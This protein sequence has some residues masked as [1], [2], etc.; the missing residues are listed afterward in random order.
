MSKQTRKR[1]ATGKQHNGNLFRLLFAAVLL[2]MLMMPLTANRTGAEELRQ[3][4]PVILDVV[5]LDDVVIDDFQ[6]EPT[7]APTEDPLVIPD[8]DID[9][10]TIYDPSIYPNDIFVNPVLCPSD[11][12]LWS[13]DYYGLALNCQGG[14]ANGYEL[15]VT[16]SN[17]AWWIHNVI[18]DFG[19]GQSGLPS[20]TYRIDLYHPAGGGNNL[21]IICSADDM[22]G[23]DVVP[24]FD[25]AVDQFGGSLD[26]TG[27]LSYFC[28]VF[29]NLDGFGQ[30]DELI[31][32]YVNKHTCPEGVYSDN[33]Y[34]IAQVCQGTLEG[35]DFTLTDGLGAQTT[36]T[37]AGFP[38]MATFSQVANGTITLAEAIPAGYGNPIVFC[39]AEDLAGNELLGAYVVPTVDQGAF[40]LD[41]PAETY[42]VFCDVY[43]VPVDSDGGSIIIFKFECPA[44]YDFSAN[45]PLLDCGALL[46][47]VQFNTTGPDG[48]AAQ[49]NT[50]DSINGAVY[51]GGLEA[52]NYTITETLPPTMIQAYLGSCWSDTVDTSGYGN[53]YLGDP[54]AFQLD[55]AADED[56]VCYQYNAPAEDL[57]DNAE[58]FISKWECPDGYYSDT[59]QELLENCTTEQE[60]VV[61]NIEHE[62][63][64]T[65]S[66]DT[67]GQPARASFTPWFTGNSTITEEI[68]AGYGSPLV[69]C[70]AQDEFGAMIGGYDLAF[71][72]V[73][74]GAI[75]I[76]I[77]AIDGQIVTFS[78]DWFNFPDD[79][80][81]T[82]HKWECP[83]GIELGQ[84]LEYYLENCTVVMENVE[85]VQGQLDGLGELVYTDG[86]GNLSFSVDPNSDWVVQENVPTGYAD[87]V[88]FCGWGGYI[89]QDDDSVIA[90]DGFVNLDGTEGNTIEFQTYDEFG[91]DCNWFNIPTDDDQDI[92][93]YKYTCPEGYNLYGP[94]ADPKADCVDLTNGVNFHLLPEGGIELQSQTGDSINGAVYFGDVETGAFKIWEDVPAG[95][96]DTYVTCQW[97]DNNGP[98][99]YQQ[100]V[101]A[102][103]NGSEIGNQIDVELAQGD[104][105]ICQWYN[106]PTKHWDGGDLTIYKYWCEGYVVSA[107]N[108]ELGAGVKFVVTATSGEGD[109]IFT[110]TGNDGYVGLTGLGAGTYDVSEVD[111]TW[112]KAVSSKVDEHGNVVIEEGQETI[113]TVYNCT[114]DEVK[115]DPPVKKF[116][117][118]GA[119]DFSATSDDEMILLASLTAIALAMMGFAIRMKGFSFDTAIVRIKR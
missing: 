46:N 27:D 111:Y 28:D 21:R 110:Q 5:D 70:W 78:C 77:P 17:G 50:G 41:L 7:P 10:L 31:D 87:P 99:V 113:L 65:D 102:K 12:D 19:A 33:P 20:G 82:I 104:E 30:A 18:Q 74:N 22:L 103:Y 68:P 98:Y 66:D 100:F 90:I 62:S 6:P 61:F 114:G 94:G 116:P 75:D 44:A 101:P 91:M 36:Q 73:T 1:Q 37:T 38:A 80:G 58:V 67:G 26:L 39:D 55:L 11:L 8:L 34:F 16:D 51:F 107:E 29:V 97:Y 35:V 56:I 105:L 88:V 115:K 9:D 72:P 76:T 71:Y 117:N 32:V 47:D 92:T 25:L 119:G 96:F 118:T 45:D 40:T 83:D 93:I 95:T 49:T 53:F 106:A 84:D 89:Y 85:F 112:C 43:N 64:A 2:G 23:N 14:H 81:V 52:G 24:A 42:T 13:V 57:D 63:G 60:G 15:F 109:P 3:V 4:D 48:Y 54:A 86:S 108:C 69:F 79:D 59:H